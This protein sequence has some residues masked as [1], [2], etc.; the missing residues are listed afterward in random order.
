[1]SPLPIGTPTAH[2][3]AAQ[4]SVSPTALT[5]AG[6]TQTGGTQGGAQ[7]PKPEVARAAREFE[8]IFLRKMLSSLETASHIGKPGALSSSSGDVY[9][10]MMV[11]A[12]A[13]AVANAGGIGLANYVT[14]SLSPG[15]SAPHPL[16][17]TD[18]HDPISLS[19]S[20]PNASTPDPAK[21]V[22]NPAVHSGR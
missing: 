14:K 7:K 9:S 18:G 17:P 21:G 10:S 6:A 1:M 19:N 20:K 16:H 12:L 4:S 2:P 22:T 8:A 5:Q 13:D 15:E 11:G 3:V